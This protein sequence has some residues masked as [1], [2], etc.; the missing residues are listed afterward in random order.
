MVVLKYKQNELKPTIFVE[1]FGSKTLVLQ[2]GTI[3]YDQEERLEASEVGKRIKELKS[4][5]N[6]RYHSFTLN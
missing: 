4:F 6:R 3:D 1:R 2:H 5:S